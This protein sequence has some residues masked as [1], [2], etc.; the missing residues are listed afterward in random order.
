[1]GTFWV[2]IIQPDTIL[3]SFHSQILIGYFYVLVPVPDLGL[4]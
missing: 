4:W 1:M 2:A 3:L